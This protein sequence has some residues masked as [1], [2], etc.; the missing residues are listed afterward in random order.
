MR[1]T[2]DALPEVSATVVPSVTVAEWIA[3]VTVSPGV[4]PPPDTVN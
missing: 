3:I 2:F 4:K 1:I